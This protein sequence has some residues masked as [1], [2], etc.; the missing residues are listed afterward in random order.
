MSVKLRVLLCIP[1]LQD[2][3][4]QHDVRCLLKYWNRERFDPVLLVHRREG[5]FAS[6]FPDTTACIEVDRLVPGIPKLRNLVRI[7]GYA[8][9]FRQFR[10]QA[11]I[12]FVPYTNIASAWA[13]PLSRLRFGLAVSEHAHVTASLAD[14]ESFDGP[15][16]WYYRRR[17]PRIYNERA[18]LVKCIA[19]E[20]RQDLIKNWGI[21]QDRTRLI[22]NPVDIDEIR[23]L[24]VEAVDDPWFAP[25]E[26]AR[27][28]L[29]LNVGRL[30]RQKRQ[31]VLIEAFATLRQTRKLRLAFVGRGAH[32]DKLK[33]L[34]QR[35]GVAADVRFLGFQ[36][37]PWRFM[38]RASLLA[39]SSEWEGLPCV[40]TE[41]MA[42]RLPI[43]STRCPSG[44]AEMLL[45]GRAGLLCPVGDTA[46][47][48]NA[49]ANVLD[50]QTAARERS[51]IAEANLQRFHPV[52]VTRQ[53]EALAE[54]L[55][56][57]G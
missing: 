52:P 13:R 56:A 7:A 47:L 55:A 30:A 49:I 53:Y 20:S 17:F 2:L 45:E 48:A 42:L 46:A 9:A 35:L 26:T 6:Q 25:E 5:A 41:A 34:A 31:E 12:S 33:S 8:R 10:P 43:V 21:Q 50:D 19:E 3:G 57:M 38:K 4:V 51:L 1:D 23:A 40:L 32:L 14:P 11:V 15:F 22:H 18:D 16:L 28:P 44:P 29:I 36:R 37:N 54:E 27:V 24:G 39:M